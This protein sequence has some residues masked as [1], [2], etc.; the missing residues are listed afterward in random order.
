[1]TSTFSNASKVIT[2]LALLTVTSA[3]L[4]ATTTRISIG[5]ASAAAIKSDGT[6]WTWG[7][8]FSNLLGNGILGDVISPTQIG[9]GFREVFVG[10][11]H[12]LAIKSDGSLWGWGNNS[13]GELG[14]GFKSYS[15]NL[16]IKIGEGFIHASPGNDHS[17]AIKS[18]GSLWGWG[19][20]DSNQLGN[21]NFNE[22]QYNFPIKLGDGYKKVIT[23]PQVTLA[24]KS[25]D[26]LVA[27][28]NN[29]YGALG[30][31]VFNI[32]RSPIEIL[33]NVKDFD[34]NGFNS[35]AVKQDG[36]L[37]SWGYNYS[38]QL[39]IDSFTISEVRVPVKIG[40]GFSQVSLAESAAAA[41]KNDGSLYTWG[42]ND[43][44]A[45][46]N[47]ICGFG[48]NKSTPQATGA[49]FSKIDG[50]QSV[51]LAIDN[52]GLTWSW[53]TANGSVLGYPTSTPSLSP[54]RVVIGTDSTQSVFDANAYYTGTAFSLNLTASVK[55]SSTDATQTGTAFILAIAPNGYIFTF[56]PNGWE[57][58]DSNSTKGWSGSL[59]DITTPLLINAN[60]SSL[61]GFRFFAGYGKGS[62][63]ASSLNEMLSS[64]R[65]KLIFTI[66]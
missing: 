10:N 21:T 65:F 38:G 42:S 2:A 7:G 60:V 33:Q 23:S 35:L 8:G 34:T 15:Y 5:R 57:V 36:T 37:W 18:D 56:T 16:P 53:G 4:S 1:M 22:R 52:N 26:S 31:N 20:N 51:F 32:T 14:E 61:S 48:Y 59:G 28:G 46:G 54:K 27:W 12:V 17:F 24:T 25:N 50:G 63:S 6:L 44:C 39:G 47:G 55:I 30:A 13:Y 40:E 19:K 45:L 3:A 64:N 49:V 9:E 58:F 41:L 43:Y 62:N 66:N 29:F 11:E